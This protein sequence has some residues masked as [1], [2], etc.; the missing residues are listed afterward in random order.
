MQ[1]LAKVESAVDGCLQRLQQSAQPLRVEAVGFDCFVMNLMGVDGR[2][3]PVTPLFTYGDCHPGT[4]ACAAALRRELA[5]DGELENTHQRTGTT[6]HSSYAPAQMM[7]LAKEEPAVLQRVEL[8]QTFVSWML[9]QWTGI[10]DLLLC[11]PP[12][13]MV[14]RKK[15][16][17][18][19]VASLAARAMCEQGRARWR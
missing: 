8:W 10:T 4:A 18:G 3:R 11:M 2:A 12:A 5:A 1:L 19:Q 15:R 13:P 14:N 16:C 6:V 7:R 17:V 9:G